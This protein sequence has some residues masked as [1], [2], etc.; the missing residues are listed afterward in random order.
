MGGEH[1]RF[2][3]AFGLLLAALA[4]AMFMSVFLT[5]RAHAEPAPSVIHI[6]DD[7][8]GSVAVYY[9]KYKA[10]SDAGAEIHFHGMCAS[11][12]SMVLFTE[13]TGIKA[14]ADDGAVFG[15]H[16]PFQ[17]KANGT[18]LRTKAAKKETRVV[19]RLWLSGLP[20]GLRK[21]LELVRVPSAADGDEANTMLLLPAKLLLP[22]CPMTVAAQ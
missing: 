10:L 18:V 17:M 15:F 9:R 11:A 20:A 1:P 8:G 4:L 6:T 14:C 12:C 2:W 19:W 7:P 16:K 13:F 22:K 3:V 21:Y 5:V